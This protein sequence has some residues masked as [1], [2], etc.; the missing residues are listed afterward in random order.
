M[1]DRETRT[2]P[3]GLELET[4][5]G[6]TAPRIVGYAAMFNKMSEDLGGFREKIMPGAFDGAMAEGADIRALVDHDSGK[7]IGRTTNGTLKL[8]QNSKGLKINIKPP[9]TTAGRDIAESIK[10]GDVDGMSFAFRTIEDAWHT[11][12]GQ[13]VRELHKVE[14]FEVS[15][16]T[17]PAYPDTSVGLRSLDQH[18]NETQAGDAEAARLRL[19]LVE[20]V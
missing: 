1:S 11:E 13:E 10:R 8:E 18:R 16:V 4:R 17:F 2:L 7:P 12:D 14:L 19:R 9:D 5:E 15:P 3:T 6:E 20:S